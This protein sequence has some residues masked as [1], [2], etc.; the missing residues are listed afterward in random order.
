MAV[1]SHLPHACSVDV[2]CEDRKEEEK[3]ERSGGAAQSLSKR[4]NRLR[5]DFFSLIT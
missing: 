4:R 5:L 1:A 2:V 3:G